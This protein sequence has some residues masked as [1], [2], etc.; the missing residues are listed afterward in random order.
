MVGCLEDGSVPEDEKKTRMGVPRITGVWIDPADPLPNEFVTIYATLDNCTG[1]SYTITVSGVLVTGSDDVI[2][3]MAWGTSKRKNIIR[4]SVKQIEWTDS[5]ADPCE[6]TLRITVRDDNGKNIAME[7]VYFGVGLDYDLGPLTQ[8]E[9]D[10]YGWVEYE[11]KYPNGVLL[12][13]ITD[14]MEDGIELDTLDARWIRVSH[15][16]GKDDIDWNEYRIFIENETGI[17]YQL[18]S[19]GITDPDRL[20]TD[21]GFKLNESLEEVRTLIGQKIMVRVFYNS[22]EIY[23]LDHE[24]S[25]VLN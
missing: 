11:G 24:K 10:L 22:E 19:K 13:K 23:F 7:T 14:G 15:H 2:G 16:D 4:E 21:F 5:P 1:Y 6:I 12:A 3:D 8:E 9:D 20:T 17:R 25:F 18:D